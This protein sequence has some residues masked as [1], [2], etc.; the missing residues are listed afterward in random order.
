MISVSS[1]TSGRV[2]PSTR[3]HVRQQVAA[4]AD[5]GVEI[6]E[7]VPAFGWFFH[8]LKAPTPRGSFAMI[9][10]GYWKEAAS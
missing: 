1:L 4:L 6:T 5:L 8:R 7:L 3:F 2:Q 10:F 9:G